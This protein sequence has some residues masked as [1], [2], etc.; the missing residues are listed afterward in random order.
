MQ[1]SPDKEAIRSRLLELKAIYQ[2]LTTKHYNW[3]RTIIT[4]ASGLVG[5]LVALKSEPS[6]DWIEYALF[7]GTVAFFVIG[8]SCACWAL[9][10]EID[11][12]RTR[13]L[14]ILDQTICELDPAAASNEPRHFAWRRVEAV[15][16][17]AFLAGL[18]LLLTY[19]G[20]SIRPEPRRQPHIGPHTEQCT[21]ERAMPVP[22]S[23]SQ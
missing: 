2:E 5:L 21:Q 7:V 15:A 17:I 20:Y 3:W 8:I 22:R 14:A 23:S 18:V 19:A 10:G 6:S 9:R 4:V 16:Y 12:D 13:A 1:L 11:T